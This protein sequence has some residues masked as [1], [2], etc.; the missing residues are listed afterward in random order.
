MQK[1]YIMKIQHNL[2]HG[3]HNY[4]K[5][6]NSYWQICNVQTGYSCYA[7]VWNFSIQSHQLCQDEYL[8]FFHSLC[9]CPHHDVLQPCNS[10]IIFACMELDLSHHQ[11]I[12]IW[13]IV[14]TLSP[15]CGNVLLKIMH[16]HNGANDN[17]PNKL[18]GRWV[19]IISWPNEWAS[20]RK[21]FNIWFSHCDRGI[22]RQTSP[23]C[24]FKHWLQFI[25]LKQ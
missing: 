15:H 14:C 25:Q 3:F 9:K 6:L 13:T 24:T 19:D 5:W 20:T 7:V 23:Q 10:V 4:T 11:Q 12:M 16:P 8:H 18:T 21:K 2:A 17:S 22:N 1:S